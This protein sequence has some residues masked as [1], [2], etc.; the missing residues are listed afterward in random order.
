M[1]WT[2]C[3]GLPLPITASRELWPCPSQLASAPSSRL[4]AGATR[5]A[6]TSLSLPLSGE[7]PSVEKAPII[8]VRLS[9]PLAGT[10]LS[11][12]I[13]GGGVLV[14]FWGTHPFANLMTL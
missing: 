6:H 2:T 11:C 3:P 12:S 9:D 7:A 8:G 4:Q 14:L 10:G 5:S 1:S 13:L